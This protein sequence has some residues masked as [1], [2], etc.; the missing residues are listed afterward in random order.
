M[1]RGEPPSVGV[2]IVRMTRRPEGGLLITITTS[3]DVRR[4]PGTRVENVVALAD[5]MSLVSAFITGWTIDAEV[6]TNG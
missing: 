4:T 1:P 3:P 6:V 5:A 2:C